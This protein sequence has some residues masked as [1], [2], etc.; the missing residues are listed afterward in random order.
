VVSVQGIA[1]SIESSQIRRNHNPLKSPNLIFGQPLRAEI[2]IT[3]SKICSIIEQD[4]N[5]DKLKTMAV[6]VTLY[7][8]PYLRPKVFDSASII[9][10]RAELAGV[11]RNTA[12]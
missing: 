12:R 9:N 1:V 10:A 8:T 4:V 2:E 6:T 7:S 3:Y 11:K 5:M